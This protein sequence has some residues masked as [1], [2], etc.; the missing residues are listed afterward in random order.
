MFAVQMEI[1]FVH[2][3]MIRFYSRLMSNRI[4]YFPL[5]GVQ[6][7]KKQKQT[8]VLYDEDKDSEHFLEC[9]VLDNLLT[10]L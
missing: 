10:F 6:T 5:F 8:W 4:V 3:E 7:K 1:S 2:I 9:W